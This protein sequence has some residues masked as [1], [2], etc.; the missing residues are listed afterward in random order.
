MSAFGAGLFL[1][2]IHRKMIYAELM[3]ITVVEVTLDYLSDARGLSNPKKIKSL[4]FEVHTSLEDYINDKCY[5]V[6]KGKFG[7]LLLLLPTLQSVAVQ[8]VEQLQFARLFGV[9]KVDNLLQ[10]MLLGGN[11]KLFFIFSSLSVNGILNLNFKQ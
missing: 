4:R 3:Q 10:E 11:F 9:T 8:M 1:G 6:P 7:E 5:D 2:P